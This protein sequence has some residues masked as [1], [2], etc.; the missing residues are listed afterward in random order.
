MSLARPPSLPATPLST[1]SPLAPQL[2]ET[3]L[4]CALMFALVAERLSAF[5]EHA[6][7]ITHAQGITLANDWLARTQ[8]RFP[9]DQLKRLSAASDDMAREIAATLSREAGLYTAHDMTEA[10]DPNYQSELAHSMM[11]ECTRRL[12]E[13]DAAA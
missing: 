10:L 9:H 4:R 6:H 1:L 2:S 3:G 13:L 8:R 11:D 12:T 5:Y 7:W